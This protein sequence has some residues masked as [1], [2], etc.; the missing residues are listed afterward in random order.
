MGSDADFIAVAILSACRGALRV[1]R[2][3]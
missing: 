2:A 1:W 3:T